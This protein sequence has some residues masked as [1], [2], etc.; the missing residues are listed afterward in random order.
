MLLLF[1]VCSANHIQKSAP[2]RKETTLLEQRLVPLDPLDDV[3][4]PKGFPDG[5]PPRPRDDIFGVGKLQSL[6]DNAPNKEVG[7]IIQ[8]RM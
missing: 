7:C 1:L 8:K 3:P 2:L 5:P 4:K 6:L